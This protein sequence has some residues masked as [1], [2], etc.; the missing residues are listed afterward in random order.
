MRYISEING[1][2][3]RLPA[4]PL[5]VNAVA[6]WFALMHLANRAGWP[7]YFT[8]SR[9]CLAGMLS[10]SFDTVERAR[11]ELV[12][13]GLLRYLPQPGRTPPRY[14]LISTVT[15]LQLVRK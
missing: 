14:S 6:L 12:A 7:Q 13:A 4:E 11:A 3:G 9:S 1:F 2:W 5:S 10:V 15:P 8:A